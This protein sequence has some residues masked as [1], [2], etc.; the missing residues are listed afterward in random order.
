MNL[1]FCSICQCNIE[2]KDVS[3]LRCKHP[4]HSNCIINAL[5]YSPEC[6]VC[7]DVVE[8]ESVIRK[9]TSA[10][11]NDLH[12]HANSIVAVKRVDEYIKNQRS[13]KSN[14]LLEFENCVE[15]CRKTAAIITKN[16]K[17]QFKSFKKLYYENHMNEHMLFNKKK[18]KLY[19][20]THKLKQHL[21]TSTQDFEHYMKYIYMKCGKSKLLPITTIF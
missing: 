1:E 15:D 21:N 2:K 20:A 10:M 13:N 4:F 19:Q 17:K 11:L 14:I 12:E 8:S 16:K 9:L 3:Y 18:Q 6:P 5:R 7:R